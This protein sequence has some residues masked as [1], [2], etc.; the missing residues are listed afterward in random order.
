MNHEIADPPVPSSIQ[1]V[2]S[3]FE[4]ELAALKFPDLD[5]Q[6]LEQAARQVCQH[7]E[8]LATAEAAL[9]AA[10]EALQESQDVLAQ[11]CHRAIAY[12]RVYA[13]DNQELLTRL[14]GI[15]LPRSGRSKGASLL[16]PGNE[17][18]PLSRRGRRPA[19][20][21]GPLFLDSTESGE[22]PSSTQQAA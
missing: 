22:A 6:V 16:T 14:D 13:E 20:T 5:S 2:L 7:A 10:R 15:H 1:A 19:A 9:Q 21:S 4:N 8:A 3:L 18:R 11:K 12:A 17:A